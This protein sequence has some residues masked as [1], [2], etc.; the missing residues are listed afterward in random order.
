VY[1][2]NTG[3]NGWYRT[4]PELTLKPSDVWPVPPPPTGDHGSLTPE[5]SAFD[6]TRKSKEGSTMA[7]KI[8]DDCTTCGV[9][10]DTCPTG[11]IAEGDTKYS[12]T[13]ACTECLACIDACPTGAIVQD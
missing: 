5:A 3:V 11:A 12:I 9:C 1:T 10:M 2:A 4:P 8:T 13:D 6:I 7:V